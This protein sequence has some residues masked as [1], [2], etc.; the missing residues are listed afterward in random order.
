[1][2]FLLLYLYFF[3]NQMY[4]VYKKVP[5]YCVSFKI[6]KQFLS[7]CNLILFSYLDFITKSAI[8]EQIKMIIL[9]G[10]FVYNISRL[11]YR[12]ELCCGVRSDGL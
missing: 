2:A 5:M 10:S 12:Y 1:M 3:H 9:R 8:F 4:H 11:F 7:H 6:F